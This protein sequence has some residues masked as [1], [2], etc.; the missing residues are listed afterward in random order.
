MSH[1]IQTL[2][3]ASP[4]AGEL[5]VAVVSFSEL[6]TS[7]AVVGALVLLGADFVVADGEFDP[8]IWRHNIWRHENACVRTNTWLDC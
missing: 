8:A 2:F 6:I 3:L 5:F 7:S 4:S 1:L